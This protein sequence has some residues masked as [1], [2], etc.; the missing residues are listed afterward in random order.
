VINFKSRGVFVLLGLLANAALA[1]G[2][3]DFGQREFAPVAPLSRQR[4]G[5]GAIRPPIRFPPDLT[6]D[7]GQL[8]A[9]KFL[10][11]VEIVMVRNTVSSGAHGTRTCCNGRVM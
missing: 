10:A 2:A 8:A 1:R 3:V 4:Q 5:D 9:G 6:A 11:T 7:L